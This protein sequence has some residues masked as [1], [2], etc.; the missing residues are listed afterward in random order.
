MAS[1]TITANAL[2]V[3]ENGDQIVFEGEVRSMFHPSTDGE[4][5]GEPKP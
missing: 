3:I 5:A 2:T 1:A 4:R